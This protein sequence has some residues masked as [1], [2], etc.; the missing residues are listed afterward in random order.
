MLG[1]TVLIPGALSVEGSEVVFSY[2]LHDIAGHSLGINA[3]ADDDVPILAPER[4]TLLTTAGAFPGSTANTRART[5]RFAIDTGFDPATIRGLR[6]DGYRIRL[7]M[8]HRI[9][10][11]VDDT[12]VIELDERTT[13]A[14][15]IVL[16]QANNTIVQFRIEDPF[17]GF[18]SSS[19]GFAGNF[20]FEPQIRGVGEGWTNVGPTETGIQLTYTG[21]ELPN[22]IPLTVTTANWVRT[23][24]AVDIDITELLDE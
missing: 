23:P 20:R 1:P 7:P 13:I 2:E 6:L 17:D 11:A 12:S 5:A 21:G 10:I 19:D 18:D 22:P 24:V 3:F 4:W 8:R 15:R 16:P 14:L 9:D